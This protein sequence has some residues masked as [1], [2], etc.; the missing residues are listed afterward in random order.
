MKSLLQNFGYQEKNGIFLYPEETL[1]LMETNRLEVTHNKMP[2]SIQEGYEFL[3]RHKCSLIKYRVLL[4][5]EEVCRRKSKS[6]SNIHKQTETTKASQ[7]RMIEE[8]EEIEMVQKKV[9]SELETELN[10]S[11]PSKSTEMSEPHVQVISDIFQK[12]R[13]TAPRKLESSVE[14]DIP[15]YCVF[16]PNNKTRCD[17]DFNLCISEES[18][19]ERK[20]NDSRPTIYAICS[21][22]NISFYKISTVDLPSCTDENNEINFDTEALVRV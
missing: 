12:L 21:G 18:I 7:K 3:L 10:R 17:Y 19:L 15:D 13:R 14:T 6:C 22:D 2:L 16:F 1:F 5:Y 11:D 8:R 4:K 9:C 20:L